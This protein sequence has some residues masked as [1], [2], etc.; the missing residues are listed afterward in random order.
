MTRSIIH[1]PCITSWYAVLNLDENGK[2][3][4]FGGTKAAKYSFC[5]FHHI[6]HLLSHPRVYQR[7]LSSVSDLY[8]AYTLAGL[9]SSGTAHTSNNCSHIYSAAKMFPCPLCKS[10]YP[11]EGFRRRHYNDELIHR[12]KDLTCKSCRSSHATLQLYYTVWFSAFN[13]DSVN[14]TVV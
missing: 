2:F 8:R 4:T 5:T 12:P 9:C 14:D 3:V 13:V 11:N 6:T 7:P 10:R 1:Q